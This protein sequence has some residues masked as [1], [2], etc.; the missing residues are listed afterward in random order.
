[1]IFSFLQCFF[2]DFWNFKLSGL[3][4]ALPSC[5]QKH[6][7][8]KI[9]FYFFPD[10]MDIMHLHSIKENVA[11]YN[12]KINIAGGREQIC[13]GELARTLTDY[14]DW[15]LLLSGGRQAVFS[16][17]AK[18]SLLPFFSS[19]AISAWIWPCHSCSQDKMSNLSS[20]CCGDRSCCIP[21]PQ[22]S[23]QPRQPSRASPNNR[24]SVSFP[25]S[26]LPTKRICQA[27]FKCVEE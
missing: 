5:S 10:W 16:H 22:D 27:Q 26:F 25:E 17:T 14:L 11:Q 7:R 15:L 24:F 18:W 13:L 20:F 1:M 12:L 19:T 21:W 3:Q 6:G 9:F 2:I 23:P 8:Q 4:M